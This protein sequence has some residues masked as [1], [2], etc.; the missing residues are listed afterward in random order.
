LYA[1]L[2]VIEN[3]PFLDSMR[4]RHTLGCHS[5]DYLPAKTGES[6]AAQSIVHFTVD[7]SGWLCCSFI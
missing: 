4:K 7:C 6:T 2:Q 5:L 1:S 3:S